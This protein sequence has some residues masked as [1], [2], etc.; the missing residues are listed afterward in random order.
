MYTG[1]AEDGRSVSVS[2]RPDYQ[3][4]AATDPWEH[5]IKFAERSRWVWAEAWNDILC[6]GVNP[7]DEEVRRAAEA[8]GYEMYR[9]LPDHSG[10][11]W[12]KESQQ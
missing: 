1:L 9:W 12:R 11:V 6:L 3:C 5:E 2:W 7:T 4:I 8:R 10:K